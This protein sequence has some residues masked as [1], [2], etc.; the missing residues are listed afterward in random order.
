VLVN[1]QPRSGSLELQATVARDRPR[2]VTLVDPEGLPVVG[3]RSE[4]MTFH[5]WDTEPTL[6]A[7]SFFLT[8]L[9]P[10]RVQR[11]T[12]WHEDRQ[13]IGFLLAH[14]D[15]DAPYIVRMQPW[16]T[17]TG[18]IL[19]ENGQ[20]LAAAGPAGK[21]QMP[22]VLSLGESGLVT[23][24]DPEIGVHTDSDTDA[25]GRFRLDRLVPGQKYTARVYRGTGQFAGLAFENLVLEPG[26]TRNFGDIR[27]QP[28]VSVLGR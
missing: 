16:A 12:F 14:G 22:A 27:T 11:I 9:H 7:S 10:D 13:L 17:V 4:G 15:D 6:R 5:P 24:P 23:N 19:D 18:R 28:P 25:D 26:E 3:A 21:Q 8:K 20:A 1:P 2:R